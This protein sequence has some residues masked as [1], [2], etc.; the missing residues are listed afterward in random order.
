MYYRLSICTLISFFVVSGCSNDKSIQ[1]AE[2]TFIH[3]S[4]VYKLIDNEL[5]EVADMNSKKIRKLEILKPE[6]KSLGNASL[7]YIKEGAEAKVQGLY[8]GNKLYFKI[9]LEGINDLKENYTPGKFDIDFEDSLGFIIHTTEILTSDLTGII[10]YDD[11]ISHYLYNG[12]TEMST[13]I[14]SS[15]ASIT[16]GSTVKRKN[17]SVYGY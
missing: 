11:K 3:D 16:I 14:N 5:V 9:K 4:K 15:I 13:E 2:N 8:R 17:K 6:P 10:G 1:I 7:S 12:K